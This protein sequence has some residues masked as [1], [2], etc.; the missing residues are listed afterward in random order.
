MIQK[1]WSKN[2]VSRHIFLQAYEHLFIHM[3]IY[4]FQ[5]NFVIKHL[6]YY[7]EKKSSLK[8]AYTSSSSNKYSFL[9]VQLSQLYKNKKPK[10]Q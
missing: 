9:K 8:F 10:F 1:E 7:D 4:L 6:W 2:T 3:Q 5:K